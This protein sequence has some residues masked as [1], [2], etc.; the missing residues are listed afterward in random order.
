MPSIRKIIHISNQDVAVIDDVVFAPS[1]DSTRMSL[2]A[3]VDG[4]LVRVKKGHNNMTTISEIVMMKILGLT[5]I[6]IPNTY[7]G[8]GFGQRLGLS[9]IDPLD[10]QSDDG[11]LYIVSEMI[12][13]YQ[14]LGQ[15]L[16]PSGAGHNFAKKPSSFAE[17]PQG[18]KDLMKKLREVEKKAKDNNLYGDQ[19]KKDKLNIFK[20][21][22]KFM[23]S[24]IQY[25]I[26]RALDLALFTGN[27]DIFN[28]ELANTG[29]VYDV[30]AK[31]LKLTIISQRNSGWVGFA[32]KYK[33]DSIELTK[34]EAKK[35]AVGKNDF[36]PALDSFKYDGKK[37]YLSKKEYKPF[38]KEFFFSA[39]LPL[40]QIAPAG[41]LAYP[42]NFPFAKYMQDAV[43][44]NSE[45]Q[46]LKTTKIDR[47]FYPFI[48][49]S[50][51][52]S[53]ISNQVIDKVIDDWYLQ[54]GYEMSYKDESRQFQENDDSNQ[55]RIVKLA[56]HEDKAHNKETLKEIIKARRDAMIERFSNE[57]Y[58]NFVQGGMDNEKIVLDAVFEVKK[59]IK[60]IA[61][62]NFDIKIPAF[63]KES[64]IDLFDLGEKSAP[65]SKPSS[66]LI[67]KK[68]Q[69]NILS[70]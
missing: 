39:E 36:D 37:P 9:E 31:S 25:D 42:R 43:K 49:I 11:N 2:K 38:G 13:R 28:H 59:A 52:L 21:M 57:N 66:P 65:S 33:E 58:A 16:S 4:Q 19:Y 54:P 15:F 26:N 34:S 64:S 63:L 27:I 62:E 35:F 1:R 67:D 3:R 60:K 7:Y 44:V 47:E 12:E 22:V 46:P 70:I 40:S 5:G 69:K 24:Q 45:F 30:G 8:I 20:E 68:D 29:F 17:Y 51:R 48:D 14:D 23:P 61:G 10:L 32:G 6:N 53:L 18:Y 41:S 55:D 56:N 50:L